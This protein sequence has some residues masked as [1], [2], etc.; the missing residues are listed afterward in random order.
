MTRNPDSS[1]TLTT[2]VLL[3]HHHHTASDF[4]EDLERNDH[5][6][7]TTN[8]STGLIVECTKASATTKG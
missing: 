3:Y 4:M 6:T 1:A 8:P 2:V 7:T 5:V